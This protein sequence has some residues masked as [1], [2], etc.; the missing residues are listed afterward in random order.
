[1]AG[2]DTAWWFLKAF[3]IFMLILL[4]VGWRHAEI[5]CEQLEKA[6]IDTTRV[7]MQFG[8]VTKICS[9]KDVKIHHN[10]GR[11]QPCI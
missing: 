10:D 3:G 7:E 6:P 5:D 1:M 9:E 8:T 4:A 11:P 2:K